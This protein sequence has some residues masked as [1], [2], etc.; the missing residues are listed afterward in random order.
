[1]NT[2]IIGYINKNNKKLLSLFKYFKVKNGVGSISNAE[3]AYFFVPSQKCKENG[4]YDPA[5]IDEDIITKTD[6]SEEVFIEKSLDLVPL[7]TMT[8]KTK[9]LK[10]YSLP[11]GFIECLKMFDQEEIEFYLNNKF[12]WAYSTNKKEMLLTTHNW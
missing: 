5:K 8:L 7:T 4:V 9:N 11:S 12:I 2:K 10:Y 1:M 6:I 3:V